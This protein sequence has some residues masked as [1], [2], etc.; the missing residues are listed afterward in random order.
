MIILTFLVGLISIHVYKLHCWIRTCSVFFG[1][2]SLALKDKSQEKQYSVDR[3]HMTWNVMY[4]FWKRKWS[5]WRHKMETFSTLLAI[6]A[7]NSTVTD[8]FPHKGQWRR[9][10]MFSFIC[11]WINGWVNNSEAGDLRRH[12]THYDV[13]AMNDNAGSNFKKIFT[14]N[15]FRENITF[16]WNVSLINGNLVCG[17]TLACYYKLICMLFGAFF[18]NMSFQINCAPMK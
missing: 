6:Y 13:T 15:N 8:E 18:V 10:L 14:N 5:R 7:G 2:A 12:H 4:L 3:V 17:V 9:T 1:I 16:V 11:A